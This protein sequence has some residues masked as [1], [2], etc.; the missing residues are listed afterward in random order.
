MCSLLSLSLRPF[1]LSRFKSPPLS[2]LPF[3]HT[4]CL[5]LC[6][7]HIPKNFGDLSKQ[8]LSLK[9][10]VLSGKKFPRIGSEQSCT[11]MRASWDLDPT[12]SPCLLIPISPVLSTVH[13]EVHTS[14]NYGE[15]RQNHDIFP[16]QNFHNEGM[17]CHTTKHDG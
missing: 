1:F 9:V 6:S 10:V 16:L 17:A 4:S 11:R 5:C 7:Q 15:F 13:W 8:F 2:S 3:F 12:F 14:L